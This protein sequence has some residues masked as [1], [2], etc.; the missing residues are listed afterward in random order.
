MRQI[1]IVLLAAFALIAASTAVAAADSTVVGDSNSGTELQDGDF[2]RTEFSEGEVRLRPFDNESYEPNTDA[3]ISTSENYWAQ[4]FTANKS[5]IGEFGV[6]HLRSGDDITLTLAEVDSDGS[7]NMSNP[8]YE[9]DI[10][11]STSD[12]TLQKVQSETDV[13]KGDDYYIVISGDL[14][15]AGRIKNTD[16]PTL[17]QKAVEPNGNEKDFYLAIY[18]GH[19]PLSGSYTSPGLN[20]TDPTESQVE[21][22]QTDTEA[23]VELE[24]DDGTGISTVD[25]TTTTSSGTVSLTPD[26][27]ISQYQHKVTF[28]RD[29]EGDD[30]SLSSESLLFVD[31]KPS[32][33]DSSAKPTD[34]SKISDGSVDL[35]VNVSD[36][37]FGT[38]QGEEVT[39]EFRDASDDSVIGTDTLSQDGTASATWSSPT[40]G[41]NSWYAVATDSYGESSQSQ[42]FSVSTPDELKIRNE[43]SPDSL[44]SNSGEATVT[45]YEKDGDKVFERQASDGTIDMT[46]LPV[47]EFTISVEVDGYRTRQAIIEDITEQQNVYLLPESADAV[48][49]RF[50]ISD[51][52][53]RFVPEDTTIFVERPITRDG[54]TVYRTV[55]ADQFGA[56]G[57]GVQL[58]RDQRYRLRV[59]SGEGRER[60]FGFTSQVDESV[61][62]EISELEFDFE[63]EDNYQWTSELV[64]NDTINFDFRD[65][66]GETDSIELTITNRI[67]NEVV[68]QSQLDGANVS[69]THI[70]NSQPGPRD[71]YIVEW[72]GTRDGAEISGS[73]VIGQSE[74]PISLPGLSDRHQSIIGSFM[75]VLIA[76]AF[77]RSNAA[78]GGIIISIMAGFLWMIGWMPGSVSGIFIAVALSLSIVYRMAFSRGGVQ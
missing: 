33:D 48:D 70:L 73:T 7:P 36:P 61:E 56:N 20:V 66:T 10:T 30:A 77:G 31:E 50:R 6:R 67:S 54:E 1:L 49:V 18:A 45:F 9:E 38:E 52:A 26:S 27:S 24:G 62:L 4:R 57:Y 40:M 8:L 16:I 51:P 13:T 37:E 46:G 76:G 42:R 12:S 60:I 55:A 22:S 39:V 47:E 5:H 64:N 65:P 72:T 43:S 41:D 17:P 78:A 14:T 21:L 3:S 59:V 68:Y 74:I 32:I 69:D 34:G 2:N 58:E 63:S 19:G 75:I 53:G 35:K 15:F 11:T 23:S 71:A 28:T 29:G 25:S 44:I